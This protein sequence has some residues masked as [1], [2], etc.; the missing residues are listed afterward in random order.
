MA[1]RIR[2]PVHHPVDAEVVLAHIRTPALKALMQV[3]LA[4][5]ERLQASPMTATEV[6]QII[7]SNSACKHALQAIALDVLLQQR[8]Q[9]AIPPVRANGLTLEAKVMGKPNIRVKG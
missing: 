6:T 8:L 9:K 3:L 2:H 5:I 1:P 7:A 4:N